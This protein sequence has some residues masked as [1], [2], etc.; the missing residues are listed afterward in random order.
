MQKHLFSVEFFVSFCVVLVVSLFRIDRIDLMLC[1]CRVYSSMF[2]DADISFS[3]GKSAKN[4]GANS[5]KRKGFDAEADDNDVIDDVVEQLEG[6]EGNSHE[7]NLDSGSSLMPNNDSDNPCDWGAEQWAK[8]VIDKVECVENVDSGDIEHFSGG[9]QGTISKFVCAFLRM[10]YMPLRNNELDTHEFDKINDQMI[11]D[12]AKTGVGV[13][14]FDK[15]KYF[16][17]KL[18]KQKIYM[19][20]LDSDGF[21]KTL[22]IQYHLVSYLLHLHSFF[23]CVGNVF[24]MFHDCVSFASSCRSLRE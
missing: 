7:H 23:V 11:K 8:Y 17:L 10:A 13:P 19:L 9:V 6:D 22:L 24:C 3:M 2:V 16:F 21:N 14:G 1:V 5:K 4:G 18:S 20:P 12:F 15:A